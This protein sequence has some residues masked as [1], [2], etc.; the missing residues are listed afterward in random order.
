MAAFVAPAELETLYAG[1]LDRNPDQSELFIEEIAGFCRSLAKRYGWSL[2]ED[3][4]AEVVGEACC[5]LLAP[6]SR[7]FDPARGTM[8]EF[9]AGFVMN[10][11]RRLR[12]VL[13]PPLSGVESKTEIGDQLCGASGRVPTLDDVEFRKD[14]PRIEAEKDMFKKIRSDEILSSAPAVVGMALRA[15]HVEDETFSNV[16][17]RLG[18][19]RFKLKRQVD[20]FISTQRGEGREFRMCA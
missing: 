10:A 20:L 14:C 7:R 8:K 5:A 1:F 18:V 6:G 2:P 11:V 17:N 12:R 3:I 16:A 19:S 9:L 13:Y 15:V 4:R